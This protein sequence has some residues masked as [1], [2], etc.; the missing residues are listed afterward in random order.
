MSVLIDLSKVY[1]KAMS[2]QITD[3]FSNIFSASLSA[4]RKGYSCQST[5][6]NMNENFKCALDRGEYIACINMD[7]SKPFDCLPHCLTVCK[8][9]AYGL[10]RTR[11]HWLLVICTNENRVK[12]G[13]LKN[14]W[15]EISKGV[16]QFFF[17][18]RASDFQYLHE[19]YISL[20]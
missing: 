19:W 10:S 13:S 1:E 8:L 20:C 16:A 9:H 17:Y 5:L 4:F 15:K 2:L 3:Y 7:I 14:D 11:V 12:I 6:F 18:I